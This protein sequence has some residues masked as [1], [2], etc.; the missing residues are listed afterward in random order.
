MNQTWEAVSVESSVLGFQWPRF[1]Q[2]CARAYQ[3]AIDLVLWASG[4]DSKSL[5]AYYEQSCDVAWFETTLQA[6][7]EFDDDD[8]EDDDQA[9]IAQPSQSPENI[10]IL[11]KVL[12]FE[13]YQ[14]P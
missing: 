7:P 6:A 9:N 10:E 13:R 14:M 8:E 3:S 1:G 5:K 2:A 4:Y 11:L 12:N